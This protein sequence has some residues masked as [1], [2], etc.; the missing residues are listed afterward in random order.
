[1]ALA[2][3]LLGPPRLERDGEAVAFDT[4][5][6]M[7]VLATWRSPSGR[8]SS[9]ERAGRDSVGR[10][11][12]VVEIERDAKRLLACRRARQCAPSIEASSSSASTPA[13]TR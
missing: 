7:A 8:H 2:I 13:L 1:M 9:A 11:S 10:E 12:A 6:A 4:R 3:R 5:K